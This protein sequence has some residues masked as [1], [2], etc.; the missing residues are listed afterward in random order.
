MHRLDKFLNPANYAFCE[1]ILIK[2]FICFQIIAPHVVNQA[3]SLIIN[4]VNSKSR[5]SLYWL[6]TL[7][8]GNHQQ[9]FEEIYSIFRPTIKRFL[10]SARM[11]RD[12]SVGIATRYSLDCPGIESRWGRVFPH[13]SRPALRATQ[14]PIPILPR[15]QSGREVALITHPPI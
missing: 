2:L 7:Q 5:C 1:Y 4:K 11:G 13:H 15:G 12:N 6:D 10:S 14:P 8:P 9:I 3:D